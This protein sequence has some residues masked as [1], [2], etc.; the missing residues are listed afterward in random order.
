MSCANIAGVLRHPLVIALISGALAALLFPWFTRQWQ[1][2]QSELALKQSLV[3]RIAGSST[4]AV[5]QGVSLVNGQLRAAGGRPGESRAQI[6]AVLRNSWLIKRATARSA[7]VTYFPDLQSCW[8]RYEL[9]TA[10]FLGLGDPNL[11]A[12]KA[13]AENIRLYVQAE[14]KDVCK[15]LSALPADVASRYREL[16]TKTKWGAF[17]RS[18][19]TARF[20][21]AYAIL[22]ELLLIDKDRIIKSIVSA[23]AASFYHGPFGWFP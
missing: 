17:A 21:N 5:R 18:T 6:Y 19:E 20:R 15:P 13:K 23:D 22:A 1:D 7:I 4:T 16:Q 2:R 11:A 8:H 10:D 14:P 9:V 12:R 3:E